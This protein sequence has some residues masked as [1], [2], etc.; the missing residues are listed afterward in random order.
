[1]PLQ[2]WAVLQ[3]VVINMDEFDHA[4]QQEQAFRDKAIAHQLKQPSET[5]YEDEDGYRYCL[6]CGQDIPLKRI[7]ALPH[8]VRC[9]SCQDKKE[10]SYG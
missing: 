10:R 9:V 3:K 5:P 6:D 7:K 4:Q 2:R 8:V 1:M